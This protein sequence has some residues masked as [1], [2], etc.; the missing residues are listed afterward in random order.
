MITNLP[1]KVRVKSFRNNY[2]ALA[3]VTLL[4]FCQGADAQVYQT[5]AAYGRQTK[6]TKVDTT[7]LIPTV[8]GVPTLR[9]TVINQ[10]AIAHDT[11]NNKLYVYDGSL[12]TWSEVGS[13]DG[14]GI[15]ALGNG[16][17]LTLVNDSTYKIDTLFITTRL[18][19]QHVIDSLTAN[20]VTSFAGETGAVNPKKS[21]YQQYYM[22]T[23][24][25]VNDT[26]LRH[27]KGSVTWDIDL[28]N[29]DG[30][31]GSTDTT[32][33]SNRINLKVNIADTAAMLAPYATDAQVNVKADQQALVDTAAAIR[34]DFPTG[35]AGTVTDFSSGDLAPLFTTSVANSTSSPALTYLL[36]NAGEY[37]LF[38]RASGTGAPS[39]L[40]SIDSSWI[41]GLHT[42]AYYDTKYAPYISG[43]QWTSKTDETG[44]FY[45]YR[46]GIG[47]TAKAKFSVVMPNLGVLGGGTFPDTSGI[48]LENPTAAAVGAQQYSPLLTFKGSG[49]KTTAT[50]AAVD[51][52]AR[53]GLQ[54]I[55][56]T[57]AP[58]GNLVF[59]YRI[60]TGSWGIGAVFSSGGSLNSVNGFTSSNGGVSVAGG[61]T[62]NAFTMNSGISGTNGIA[63]TST[64][65]FGVGNG[66]AASG[67]APIQRSPRFYIYSR[68]WTGAASQA[69]EFAFENI[70]VNG[71]TPIT[72][73]LVLSSQI[74]S[75]GYTEKLKINS[76][77]DIIQNH[78]AGSTGIGIITT[79]DATAQLEIKSSTKGFLP[80]RMTTTERD[81]IVTPAEGLEIFNTTTKKKNFYNGTAW[82]VVTSS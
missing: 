68:A 33:L 32:S 49:W 3:I 75:T 74:N 66:S 14:V 24:Y 23:S 21:H 67:G 45:N 51:V 9:S 72:S 53:I 61:V 81:A 63:N 2:L 60:G 39:Y 31:G 42:E 80:P 54:T 44:I 56:G 28:P 27:R 37:T 59:E 50:A 22:D 11:C 35:G 34:A 8:C 26:T 62:G 69:S 47:D 55:Q 25:L 65:G 13:V 57:T 64:N 17:G 20:S 1:G 82:E 58:S 43:S 78:V 16:Y 52:R 10:S 71:T 76:G 12:Q 6:R 19:L 30:G 46:V 15:I 36:S 5:D 41:P 38:G 70:P 77:G 18:R 29:D 73:N 40:S 7:L 79:I 4:S 48:L